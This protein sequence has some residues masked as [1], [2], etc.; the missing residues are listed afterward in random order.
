MKPRIGILGSGVVAKTLAKGFCDKGYDVVMG[1]RDA[2][3]LS[4]FA[5]TNR[6]G[7][8]GLAEAAAQAEIVVLAVKGTAARAV[9]KLT[10]AEDLEGKIVIDTTNPI[11]DEPPDG[12][13][14]RY[15]TRANESLMEQLQADVPG[16]RFV[17]AW[18]T[19]GNVYMVDPSFPDG[20]PTMFICGNEE[21]AKGMVA[22]ILREF[23]FDPEDMGGAS[24][25]RPLEA[26]CQ[27]WCIPGFLGKGWNHAFK[28]IRT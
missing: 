17:K 6:V 13:V 22:E 10:G 25:A 12:S 5:A 3:K 16:A 9:L 1:T 23:G 27:L 4:E 2:S 24:G 8:A 21:T 11:A 19:I 26:L 18:N 7:V 14:L 20:K 15:F 28:L